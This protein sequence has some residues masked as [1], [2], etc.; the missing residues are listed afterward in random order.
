MFGLVVFRS[1]G[2]LDISFPIV[3]SGVWDRVATA[4]CRFPHHGRVHKL[5]IHPNHFSLYL[6]LPGPQVLPR[7]FRVPLLHDEYYG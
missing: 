3:C 7:L 5:V 4:K 2:K 6:A 1:K